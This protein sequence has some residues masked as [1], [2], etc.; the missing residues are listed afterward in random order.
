MFVGDDHT[1]FDFQPRA[2]W[3]GAKD[4]CS[5]A[6]HDNRLTITGEWLTGNLSR[7]QNSKGNTSTSTRFPNAP[8]KGHINYF[9][10][11][12]ESNGKG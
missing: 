3:G 12:E 4:Q 6:I 10:G 5:V 1:N 2:E 7:N 9:S 8:L 11:W